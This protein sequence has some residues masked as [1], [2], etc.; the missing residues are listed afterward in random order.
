MKLTAEWQ[1]T[2]PQRVREHLSLAADDDVNFIIEGDE[3]VLR[4]NPDADNLFHA[5]VREKMRGKAQTGLTTD[6]IMLLTRGDA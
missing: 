2:I 4:K 3:V 5:H 1:I 6:E